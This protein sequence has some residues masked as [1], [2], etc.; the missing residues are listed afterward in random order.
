MLVFLRFSALPDIIASL[1]RQNTYLLYVAGSVAILA[2]VV[3]GRARRVFRQKPAM[4]WLW[5]VFWMIF[6]VPFSSWK[7]GSFNF[8]V[9][10]IKTD[11]VIL[12]TTACLARTWTDCRKIIYTIAAAAAFTIAI[13]LIFDTGG[14]RF[15][16]ALSGSI[17][18]SNDLA[19][20]L[21]LVIPFLL[22]IAL[23]PRANLFFRLLSIT[24]GAFGIFEILRASSRGALI[25]LLLATMFAFVRGSIRQKAVV[26]AGAVVA[27]I[28][29]AILL[30]SS[31]RQRLM[32]FSNG[33]DSNKEALESSEIREYLLKQSIVYT[34]ENP[35]WGVGPN[36]FAAYHASHAPQ[37]ETKA[38]LQFQPLWYETHNSYTEISSECG[39]PA[40]MFYLAAGISTFVLLGKIRKRA[41]G[42]YRPEIVIASHCLTIGLFAYSVAIFFVNFGYYYQFPAISGL[43]VAMWFAVNR[44]APAAARGDAPLRQTVPDRSQMEPVEL[45]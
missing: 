2:S 5:F 1:S 45:M 36:Q 17:G 12:V 7:G 9:T 38:N 33:A 15:N 22:F 39:I 19:A 31:T 8:V 24:A 32:S 14:D 41:G 21:L 42:A 18:N 27:L 20:H 11:F 44:K 43:V 6:A 3:S 40:L 26:G 25:A 29:F 28:F 30:P 13:S 10:Y 35:F 34:L 23:K 37:G 16:F 4:F